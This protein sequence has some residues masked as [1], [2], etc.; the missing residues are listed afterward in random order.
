VDEDVLCVKTFFG[1]FAEQTSDE[2][3]GPGGQCVRKTEMAATNLGE[4]T[5]VLL[6][7]EWISEKK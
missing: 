7:M 3:F 2:T 4:Q 1:F 5:R 6:A